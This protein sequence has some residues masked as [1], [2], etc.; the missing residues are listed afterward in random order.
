VRLVGLISEGSGG[1]N[2]DAA[3]FVEHNGEITAAWVFDGVTGIN[4][5]A[6][7]DSPTDAAWIVARA[8]A[9]LRELA[10]Q[11]FSL[12]TLLRTL[13]D[14]LKADW[15]EASA[16]L[17]L[18]NDYDPPAAC[19]LVVKRYADGWHALRL[20]DSILLTKQLDIKRW[21]RLHNDLGG[22]ETQLRREAGQQ[23]AAGVTDFSVLLK[24]SHALHMANRK[25]RNTAGHHS[26][27]VAD[28]ASLAIP[29]YHHLGWPDA[30]LVCTD[31]FYRA[32]DTY[33]LTD[34]A[35]LLA[36]CET[37]H[38][39]VDILHKIRAVEAADKNCETYARFKPADDASAVMLLSTFAMR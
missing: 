37:S 35:G 39:I 32:V 25:A 6:Y 36:D 2:E 18:P 30:M 7:L 11:N 28:D 9:H 26:I 34:D 33:H 23:R 14:G 8:D 22:M 10:A 16:G 12:P 3:G 5:K 1:Q 17:A 21:D 38:G 4:D 13:V 29:E 20:G 31:G 24:Q 27:L 19:L 15:Q